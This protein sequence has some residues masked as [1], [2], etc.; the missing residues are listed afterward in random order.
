VIFN[1][2]AT[3]GQAHA[4]SLG[5]RS[6]ESIENSFK[7]LGVDPNAGI[8]YGNKHPVGFLSMGSDEQLSRTIGD[9]CGS[10]DTVDHE[11]KNYL[12]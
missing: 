4:N 10:F 3:D 12:L 1:N 8:L 11:I 5:L 9:P 6:I 7:I 2:G